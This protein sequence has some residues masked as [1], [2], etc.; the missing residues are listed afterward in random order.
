MSAPE[1]YFDR[2]EQVA[3]S[4]ALDIHSECIYRLE[5]YIHETYRNRGQE[6]EKIWTFNLRDG[7]ATALVSNTSA[8]GLEESIR[9]ERKSTA[10]RTVCNEFHFVPI[11]E[12]GGGHFINRKIKSVYRLDGYFCQPFSD[13]GCH[14]EIKNWELTGPDSI[15]LKQRYRCTVEEMR[16]II[17]RERSRGSKGVKRNDST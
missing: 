1:F 4:W 16:E 11:E 17:R 15:P 6:A 2:F 7:R 9:K 5:G 13:E 12:N 10:Y 14:D 3:F 8:D